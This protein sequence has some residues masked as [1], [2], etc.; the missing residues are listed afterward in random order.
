MAE[1][2]DWTAK[3][4]NSLREMALE[5]RRWRAV[6]QVLRRL[7]NRLC[8]AAMGIEPRLDTQL[9]GLAESSR[10]GAAPTS[11]NSAHATIRCRTS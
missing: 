3:H 8:A 6:E 4:L 7:V 5:E 10:R 2:T 11:P 1:S 9:A